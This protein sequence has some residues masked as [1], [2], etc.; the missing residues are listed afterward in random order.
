MYSIL[1]AREHSSSRLAAAHEKA[2][3]ISR[4]KIIEIDRWGAPVGEKANVSEI[5]RNREKST[6]NPLRVEMEIG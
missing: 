5:K 4:M 2:I 1:W 6:K 3:K